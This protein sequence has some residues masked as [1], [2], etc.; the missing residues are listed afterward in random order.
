M[1]IREMHAQH[2]VEI[3]ERIGA[4]AAP[5]NGLEPTIVPAGSLLLQ[6]YRASHN[7]E[8]RNICIAEAAYFTAM[9]RGLSPGHEVEDWLTAEN[10]VDAR[11]IGARRE[12][13]AWPCTFIVLTDPGGCALVC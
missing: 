2:A 6:R 10:E 13:Q 9:R 5:R 7:L 12:F 3:L 8:E 4:H 1:D 11:L